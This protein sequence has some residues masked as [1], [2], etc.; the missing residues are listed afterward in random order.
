MSVTV[1]NPFLTKDDLAKALANGAGTVDNPGP[2]S[3]LDYAG[4]G[5]ERSG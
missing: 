2:G 5:R 3:G 4:W 1:F